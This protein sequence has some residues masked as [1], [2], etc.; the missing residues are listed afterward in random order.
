MVRASASVP[1]GPGSTKPLVGVR[2]LPVRDGDPPG[3]SASEICVGRQP[4]TRRARLGSSPGRAERA[5]VRDQRSSGLGWPSTAPAVPGLLAR[6]PPA[7]RMG[8]VTAQE[9]PQ[10]SIA[11]PAPELGQHPRRL[12]TRGPLGFGHGS[13]PPEDVVHDPAAPYVRPLA[14]AVSD[15]LLVVAPGGLSAHRPAR[16]GGP[17]CRAGGMPSRGRAGHPAPERPY[18]AHP[19]SGRTSPSGK[20][21]L[22]LSVGEVVSGQPRSDGP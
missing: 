14:P 22:S 1:A 21:A 10:L 15:D 11:R 8:P 4:V 13:P 19:T 5:P 6:I 17:L 16:E 3:R 7:W 12:G 9:Q 18:L 2:P 20:A